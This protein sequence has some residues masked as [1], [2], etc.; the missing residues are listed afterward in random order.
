[1]PYS[2][3]QCLC[4]M[5]YFNVFSC[6]FL[7]GTQTSSNPVPGGGCEADDSVTAISDFATITVKYSGDAQEI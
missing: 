5:L 1:M 3:T 6:T 2:P 4:F 7:D